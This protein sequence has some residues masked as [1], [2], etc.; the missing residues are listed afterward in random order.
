MKAL[1]LEENEILFGADTTEGIVAVEPIGGKSMRLFVRRESRIEARDESFTPFLLVETD[2]LLKDFKGSVHLE[3]LTSTNAY[4]FLALFENWSDCLKARDFLRR[5]TGQPPS[6][7]EAPYLFFSDP[8]HQYLLLT[9]KTFF[10]GLAF[11]HVHRLAIDI[12]TT[13]APGYEFSN[14]LR[15]EDRIISIALMDNRGYAEVLFGKDLTEEEM[16]VALGERIAALDPD[17]LEGHNFFNFDLEYIVARARMYGVKLRWG[18][19]ES[20]PRVRRSRFGVAERI[21]DYSRMEVFGRHIVDTMFLLQYYDVTARELESYG[22]KA[23]ALHFGISDEEERTYLDL[24][25]I[26]SIYE[27]DPAAL[28]KYNLDDARETLA[29][30]ELLGYPF[31]LQA[32]IF[33]FSYQNILIRGNATKINALFVR[34]YLRNRCS[35]P[36]PLQKGEFAGGYTDIFVQGVVRNVVHCDVASLYPS[37]I[38]SFALKPAGDTLG[39]FLPLLRDLRTFRL[40]AKKLA[41]SAVSSHTHDYYQALQQTFKILINSFYGY[42]GTALHHFSDPALAAEVTRRGRVIIRQMIEWLRERGAVSVEIDTDGIYFVPPENVQTEEQVLHLIEQ[43]SEILPEGIEVEMDGRYAAMFSYKI[44]NYALLDKKGNMSIKGSALRSRGVEKYLREFTSALIRCL[45][46]GEGEAVRRIYLDYVARLEQH[47]LGISWL[48]KTEALSDSPDSY[49]QKIQ[50]KKR[51][52]AATYELALVCGR[53]YRAGDQV[54]YYVTGTDK[55]VRVHEN[56]RLA[57]SYDPA[58]PNENVAYYQAKLLDQ[59]IKFKEF[60]PPMPEL[61]DRPKSKPKARKKPKALP[62]P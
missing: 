16:I 62:K 50:S 37:I 32:R 22:L 33:P 15:R 59:L 38:L 56:C 3:Q 60:L 58:N 18:R 43:L 46:E 25:D 19:D 13:C 53:E 29:L 41:R 51:G 11:K 4:Q 49:R 23:A 44:K 28:I 5:T 27:H 12:E 54:S 39:I 61:V 42:L 55:K 26:R 45:L 34:E 57:S 30:S 52:R 14:P 36:K 2:R 40:E 17:V 6:S 31:F 7:R 48:A 21:I 10:K 35:I 24:S 8:V 20:E 1:E 9:G 47:Q